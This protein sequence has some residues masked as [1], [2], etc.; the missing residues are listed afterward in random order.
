MEGIL[1]ALW[2]YIQA[3]TWL[4]VAMVTVIFAVYSLI[5]VWGL[6]CIL[7]RMR[8]PVKEDAE[9][10]VHLGVLIALSFY[11]VVVQVFLVMLALYRGN[12]AIFLDYFTFFLGLVITIFSF[13]LAWGLSKQ[14][15]TKLGRIRRRRPI[16]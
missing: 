4:E 5:F 8:W 6:S 11:L 16:A 9:L 14:I 7:A 2:Q 13:I 12:N 15:Q 3:R 1:E 10:K